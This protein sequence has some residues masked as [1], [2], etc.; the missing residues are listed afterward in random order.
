M[1]LMVQ[2]FGGMTL[3]VHEIQSACR[4]T[5]LVLVL[6]PAPQRYKFSCVSGIHRGKQVVQNVL[7]FAIPVV[8]K[9]AITA[10]IPK[11][12]EWR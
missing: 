4:K 9:A 6:A 8:L 7:L 3:N 2:N 5:P 12:S 10:E 1:T 11:T